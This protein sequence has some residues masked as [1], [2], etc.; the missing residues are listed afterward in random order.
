VQWGEYSAVRGKGTL[1]DGG[2]IR[3]ADLRR[4][5][6]SMGWI[7]PGVKSLEEDA[8]VG[9][10]LSGGESLQNLQCLLALGKWPQGRI[11]LSYTFRSIIL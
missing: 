8:P 10:T 9:G 1:R 6:L 3:G 5:S 2:A 7:L 11:P 4:G